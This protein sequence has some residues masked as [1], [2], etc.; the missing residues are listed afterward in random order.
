MRNVES[1]EYYRELTQCDLCGHSTHGRVYADQPD[2]VWCTSCDR[3]IIGNPTP[4]ELE[5]DAGAYS[6]PC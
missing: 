4:D 3:P 2:V 5:F 1:T 6:A